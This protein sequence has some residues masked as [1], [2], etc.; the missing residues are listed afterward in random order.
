MSEEEL[1]AFHQSIEKI[2]D[3]LQGMKGWAYEWSENIFRYRA[4]WQTLT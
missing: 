2:V 1:A 3:N 4:D